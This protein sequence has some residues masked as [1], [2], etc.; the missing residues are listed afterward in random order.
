MPDERPG[1]KALKTLLHCNGWPYIFPHQF[2]FSKHGSLPMPYA[3]LNDLV[4][5][6][7]LPARQLFTSTML[8]K[9][10]H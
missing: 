10:R 2:Q 5:S 8:R 6:C 9:A 3:L 4:Y 7:H 1:E